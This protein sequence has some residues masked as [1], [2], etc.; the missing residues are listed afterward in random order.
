MESNIVLD[1]SFWYHALFPRLLY[2]NLCY[3]RSLYSCLCY[4][5]SLYWCLC[6]PCSLYCCLCY[7]RSQSPYNNVSFICYCQFIIEVV[8]I[9]MIM[10]CFLILFLVTV[11]GCRWRPQLGTWF[12]NLAQAALSAHLCSSAAL[13]LV[14]ANRTRVTR[15]IYSI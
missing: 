10:A 11:D 3:P 5:R 9:T 13:S 12:V 2:C 4:P 15:T 14:L 1:F 6:Y 7:P 8:A